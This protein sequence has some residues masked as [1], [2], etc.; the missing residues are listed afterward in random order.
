MYDIVKTYISDYLFGFDKSQLDTSLL[1]GKV[2]LKHV[3]IKPEKLNEMI[4]N[5]LLPFNIKAGM[6]GSLELKIASLSMK[7]W[8]IPI[9][10]N[11][12]TLLLILGPSTFHMSHDDSF[13]ADSSESY[14]PDNAY[15]YRKNHLKVK[16]PENTH[17]DYRRILEQKKQEVNSVAESI[18][19][20]IK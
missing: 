15:D 19:E 1:K 14:D 11:I 20:A 7:L 18:K 3:N 6:I 4:D 16:V 10:I 9:H 17:D 8:S 13:E 12:D 5:A 2:K